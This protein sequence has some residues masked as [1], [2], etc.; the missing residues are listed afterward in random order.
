M[1]RK[2]FII[3]AGIAA[4][5][6]KTLLV[7]SCITEAGSAPLTERELDPEKLP[8][9]HPAIR[10]GFTGLLQWL[11]DTG[12]LRHIGDLTGISLGIN[13]PLQPALFQEFP[14]GPVRTT[15]GCED[16]LGVRLI[17][18]GYPALS[19]LYHLLASPLSLLPAGS[20]S[21]AA[22]PSHYPGLEQL[23]LLENYIYGLMHLDT[24][25]LKRKKLVL[26]VCAYEYRP[27]F[28][29]PHGQ[30]ADLVFARAGISR[31]GTRPM[32]YDTVGRCFSNLP[33]SPENAREI[34]VTPAKYGLFLAEKVPYNRL[35]RWANIEADDKG[36]YEFILPIRKVFSND[37]L[38]HTA[39]V[40]FSE[41]HKNEKLAKIF[42]HS[43]KEY[44]I[45]AGL[46]D[47]TKSPFVRVSSSDTRRGNYDPGIYDDQMVQLTAVGSAALLSSWPTTSLVKE[48]IQQVNG[49]AQRVRIRIPVAENSRFSL[50][51]HT[52]RRYTSLKILSRTRNNID[53][54]DAIW[55][56]TLYKHR[57]ITNLHAPRSVAMFVYIRDQVDNET[58]RTIKIL[59]PTEKNLWGEIEKSYWAGLY[60]DNICDGCIHASITYEGGRQDT[61]LRNLAILPAFSVVTA[62]DFF[63]YV[64]SEDISEHEK[65]FLL[66]GTDDMGGIR[67]RANPAIN[68][69]GDTTRS[70]FPYHPDLSI[71]QRTARTILSVISANPSSNNQLKLK[72]YGE[73]NRTNYLPDSATRIFYPGWDITYDGP[74]G[75]GKVRYF[76]TYGLGSPFVE[77]AKLCAAANG[78]WAAASPDS[79]RTFRGQLTRIPRGI[80]KSIHP[81]TAIPL[82]DTEIGYHKES[83]MVTDHREPESYGWDGEQ[84]PFITVNK[85]VIKVNFTDIGAADYVQN[86]VKNRFDM[87]QMRKLTIGEVKYRMYCLHRCY[88]A[89][90]QVFTDFW[91]VGAEA[92]A[93][94]KDGA[95]GRCVPVTLHDGTHSWI[96]QSRLKRSGKGYLFMFCKTIGVPKHLDNSE[97]MEPLCYEI[98]FFQVHATD[99]AVCTLNKS[100]NW[101]P[102]WI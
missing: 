76:A 11:Q 31:V 13:E 4:F 86:A 45:P 3:K 77:D 43:E 99:I 90:P 8:P 87:S 84:G 83:P 102:V 52:N 41:S 64:D 27:G 98:Y 40:V 49:M 48:A 88:K 42:T 58:G 19:L 22:D 37:L 74:E 44:E 10:E 93:D 17:Q 68:L 29:T 94:W 9:L 96:T 55:E 24:K 89:H 80:A 36:L 30:H 46:F 5:C 66:G 51:K 70:A 72:I 54:W 78:M 60:E 35:S 7:S 1:N 65:L 28:K 23:D 59:G 21:E 79:A 101:N 81:P 97:R 32:V 15:A 62:P 2:E 71:E 50:S 100:G 63:P 16:F 39:A 26:A 57:K 75:R 95:S 91:L 53:A 12:W 56:N 85:P 18:P 6:A 67:F 25:E 38:F 69:P 14:P 61:V 73:L 33:A 20:G 92:V 82:L 47:L 34:A